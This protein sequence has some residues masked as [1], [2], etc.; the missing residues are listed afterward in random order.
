[1]APVAA[2]YF[3]PL[4]QRKKNYEAALEDLKNLLRRVTDQEK[5]MARD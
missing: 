1:M 2:L 5:K 3:N 4:S